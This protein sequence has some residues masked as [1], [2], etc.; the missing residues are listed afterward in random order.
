MFTVQN[1][2]DALGVFRE[3]LILKEADFFIGLNKVVNLILKEA[4]KMNSFFDL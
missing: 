4:G 3:H 1:G 2:V